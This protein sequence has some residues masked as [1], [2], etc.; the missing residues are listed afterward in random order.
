MCLAVP[1]KVLSVEGNKA[2]VDFGKVKKDVY[3][4]MI[5]PKIGDYVLVGAGIAIQKISKK[6]AMNILEEWKKL[7]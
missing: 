6:D 4:G 1:G 5:K 3:L 2:K 7:K